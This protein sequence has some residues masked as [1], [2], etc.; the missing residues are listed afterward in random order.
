MAKGLKEE[1][2]DWSK[3]DPGLAEE[4]GMKPQPGK[5]QQ[6]LQDLA[7]KSLAILKLLLGLTFLAFVYAGSRGF[8]TKFKLADPT[9]QTCFW[10]GIVAFLITYLFIYEPAV[11]YNKGQKIL[12]FIFKFFAPLVKVCP[13]ILPI[14]AILVFA[15]Y[16]LLRFWFTPRDAAGIVV[17]LGG[18]SWALHIIFSAK[19]L[20]SRQNDW[21]KANYAFSFTLIYILDLLFIAFMLSLLVDKFSF[22]G[23]FQGSFEAARDLWMTVTKQIFVLN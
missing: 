3:L 14:Y 13:F 5:L 11:V 16:P 10:S 20:R 15:S 19:T 2:I 21:L 7:H 23:F 9:L 1:N 12:A 4:G 17:F 8:F 22:V 6:R 18:F